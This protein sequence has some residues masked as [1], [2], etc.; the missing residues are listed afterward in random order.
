MLYISYNNDVEINLKEIKVISKRF[1]IIRN[2]YNRVL[3]YFQTII[4]KNRAR[5][6]IIKDSN[7]NEIKKILF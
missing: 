5:T 6:L 2:N 4:E 1:K 3:F 7:Q